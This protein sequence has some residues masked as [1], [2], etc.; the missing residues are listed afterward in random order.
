MSA[1]TPRT[2]TNNVGT[3][4]LPNELVCKIIGH[5]LDDIVATALGS[6]ELV[7]AC[8][9][10]YPYKAGIHPI[11]SAYSQLAATSK[12]TLHEVHVCSERHIAEFQP[13]MALLEQQAEVWWRKAKGV[14]PE[15]LRECLHQD[16][17]LCA[18][19]CK[20]GFVLRHLKTMRAK[21]E[22]LEYAFE[23]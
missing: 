6:S 7:S 21:L 20:L 19:A 18:E 17:L 14:S 22:R 13:Q 11:C 15:G 9:P 16:A 23:N 4:R 1:L 2:M 12:L 8:Y 3:Q 10:D 5:A